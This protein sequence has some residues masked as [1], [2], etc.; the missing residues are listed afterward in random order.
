VT[1]SI[2]RLELTEMPS[3]LADA[4]RPRVERLGYL[5]EF[6]KCAA[7]QPE[8]LLSFM[9][10]TEDL[11][12]ALPE[13]LT[14]VV[15]LTVAS[16]MRNDYERHQHERLCQRLG[17]TDKWIEEVVA[18][19][20]E[21]ARV[22]RDEQRIVQKLVIAVLAQHGHHVHQDLAAA[23]DAIGGAQAIALLLSIG[24]YMTHSLLVNALELR[25][26]V[27]SIFAAR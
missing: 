4:L 11:K 6:F 14:E 25:A 26:P 2:R 21:R 23:T 17:F 8:A 1:P 9:S 27:P 20:P 13:D 18:L 24:R 3:D 7:N 5:G 12:H 15:A 22:L 19:Q 10:F 16:V